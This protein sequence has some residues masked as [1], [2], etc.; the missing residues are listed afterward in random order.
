MTHKLIYFCKNNQFVKKYFTIFIFFCLSTGA[1]LNAQGIKGRITDTDGNPIRGASLFISELRQGTA[2]NED[3]Y[4]ELRVPA[5]VYNC[6][7]QCLGF[8]T[9]TA[10]ITIRT[11]VVE[12]NIVLREMAYSL[13]DV[14]ISA[15]REDPAY[16]IMRRAIAMAPFYLHQVSEWNAE[17]YLKGTWEVGTIAPLVRQLTKD[18]FDDIEDGSTHLSESLSETEFVA[19]N[20]YRQRVLHRTGSLENDNSAMSLMTQ[21]IYD[22]EALSPIISPLSTSAFAHYRFRYEGFFIENNRT[23]NKIAIIPMRNSKHLLSGHIHIADGFWNVHNFDISGEFLMGITFRMQANLGEVNEN[24]WLPVSH[25]MSFDVSMFGNT[26]AYHYVSSMKYTDIVENTSI[27]K[28]DALV[29]AAE[30]RRAWQQNQR[31]PVELELEEEINEPLSRISARFEN[32][33]ERERLTNRQ[34]FQLA[35]LMMREAEPE[36]REDRSLDLTEELSSNF[37]MTVDS[38]ANVRDTAFWDMRRP[39]PL[40]PEE[41]RSY[42]EREIRQQQKDSD[43]IQNRQGKSF[44]MFTIVQVSW[45]LGRGPFGQALTGFLF[46]G[47]FGLGEGGKYG[48]IR[49]RGLIP[50]SKFGF[51]TVDG[52]YIGKR[53][54]TYSKSFDNNTQLTIEPEVVWAINRKAVMWNGDASLTYAPM[55]R[56]SANLKFGQMTADFNNHLGMHPFENTVASLFFRRNYLKLYGN[57]FIEASNTIDIVNGLVL[58]TSVNY[59]RR[60]MLD[61]HSDYSFFYRDSREYWTNIPGNSELTEPPT[62]HTAATFT[63]GLEY[64]PRHYYRIR[65]NQKIMVRTAYPTFFAMWQSGVS[66]VFGSNGNFDHISGGLQQTL[67]LGLM[68]RFSYRVRAGAFVNRRNVSFPDFRHFAT[69]ELPITLSPIRAHTFNLLEYYRFSTSDKYLEAHIYYSTP[70][71][72][73]KFLPFFSNRMLMTEGVRFNYLYTPTIKNYMELGYFFNLGVEAGV[74]VGFE[75]FRYRSFGVAVSVPLNQIISF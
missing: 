54:L 16:G 28:P 39:V 51:N 1:S 61:N 57:S 31:M 27:R 56:A 38:A 60:V 69:S 25:H 3:G 9:E 18:V 23:I 20:T 74:F 53:I 2:A 64:T 72:F 65:N 19:P 45:S 21:S 37:R 43:T 47:N 15:D 30:Q 4:F 49:Y 11:V 73:L 55:R 46:G 58:N 17:V 35:R 44:N 34:A 63:L 66:G 29:L 67:E 70:F 33:M 12:H 6:V 7:F 62:N 36:R 71:L 59:A 40:T 26:F 48:N 22:T 68:Q 10:T 41:V 52:F 32:L 8:E 75:N 13:S 50:P 14:V 24:V 5:G 42:Q